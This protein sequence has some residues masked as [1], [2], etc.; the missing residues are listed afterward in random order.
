ML[1]EFWRWRVAGPT[2]RL[3]TA[4]VLGWLT[5]L[6]ATGYLLAHDA[7]ARPRLASALLTLVLFSALYLWVTL[8]DALAPSDLGP[9]GPGAATLRRRLLL[10]TLMALLVVALV[11]LVPHAAL[12][13]LAMHVVVAAGLALPPALAAG[14]IAGLL[15]TTGVGAR[16]VSGRVDAMLLVQVAFGA[17]AIAIRQLTISVAQLHAARE[18]LARAAV[19]QERLRFARDLHD[20][21]GHSLS[22]IILKSELAGRLLPASPARAAAEV[23]DV[24]RAARDALQRVRTAVVGYRQPVL[25]REL[26]AAGELLGAAGIAAEVRQAAGRLP[27]ELDALLA[28]A[29]REGVTNVIRHSRARRCE[30]LVAPLGD[31]LRLT[32]SDDG[33]ETSG[34]A[35][36]LGSGLA[37]LAER[38]AAHGAVVEAGPRPTGGFTLAVTAPVAGAAP[39]G[40]R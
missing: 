5:V 22:L 25:E 37:G 10:L 36:A 24:E 6:G 8:R 15:A 27:A 30:I 11:A 38:A 16:L 23:G 17:G 20:L 13:W 12:W 28:W 7:R 2:T 1:T 29:V 21:L 32:V 39:E 3:W 31:A 4:F 40:G 35:P 14:V 26:A 19:D 18:E 34:A 33:P 9:D